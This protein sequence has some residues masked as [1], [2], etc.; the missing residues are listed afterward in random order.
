[1]WER[2]AGVHERYPL[3]G[4]LPPLPERFCCDEDLAVIGCDGRDAEA[5]L[6]EWRQ[7]GSSESTQ[8]MLDTVL[9]EG[10][11]G[12]R[13]LNVGAGIGTVHLELLA[14]GAATA[15]DVD[16]SRDYLAVAQAEAERRGVAG[17]IQYHYGDVV[18]L[19]AELPDADI[20]TLDHVICCYPYLDRLLRAAIRPGTRLLA[21]SYPRDLWWMRTYMRAHNVWWAARRVPDRWHVHRRARVDRLM[22]DGGFHQ[23]RWTLAGKWQ[24]VLYARDRTGDGLASRPGTISP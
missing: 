10:V 15:V 4:M 11:A 6:E 20:V 24:V 16:A 8:A 21:L 2:F 5:Q 13:L 7:H 17:R 3:R 1:V 12:A 19:A 22:A 9:A 18:E 23:L 14:A